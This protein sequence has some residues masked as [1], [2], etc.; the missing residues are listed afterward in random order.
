MHSE[1]KIRC[2]PSSSNTFASA[3]DPAPTTVTIAV[4]QEECLF[5]ARVVKELLSVAFVCCGVGVS[6]TGAVFSK[7]GAGLLVCYQCKYWCGVYS[8]IYSNDF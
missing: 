4:F 1:R 7:V 3:C 8:H 2:D 5:G 6:S